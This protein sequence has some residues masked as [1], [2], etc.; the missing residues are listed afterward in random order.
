[1]TFNVISNGTICPVCSEF[2]DSE[3]IFSVNNLRYIL[4]LIHKLS[5]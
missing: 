1:M 3:Q 5:N 4:F 2:N